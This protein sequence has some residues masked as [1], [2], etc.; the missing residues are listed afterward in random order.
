M[1]KAIIVTKNFSGLV[2]GSI[3]RI[4]SA[5]EI[6]SVSGGNYKKTTSIAIPVE[7]EDFQVGLLVAVHVADA[8]SY[9]SDGITNYSK[10]LDVPQVDDGN[11]N[12]IDDESFIY[13]PSVP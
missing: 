6:D 1:K 8:D 2:V 11:G 3:L 5:E 4:G 12:M 9:Y 7:L 13:Y 10:F